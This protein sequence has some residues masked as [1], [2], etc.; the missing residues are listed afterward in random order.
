[1]AHSGVREKMTFLF[2]DLI[3]VYYFVFII[4]ISYYCIYIR[5][6]TCSFSMKIKLFILLILLWNTAHFRAED[7]NEKYVISNITS[8]NGLSNSAVLTIFQDTDGLMWFGTYDGLNCYDSKNMDVFRSN[9][10]HNEEFTFKS[11]IIHKICQAD[12]QCLWVKTFLGVARFSLIKR[13]IEEIYASSENYVIYSNS[14]GDTWVV[15]GDEL[16][17]FNPL[18]KKFVSLGR[19]IP[20]AD[21]CTQALVTDSGELWLL[22]AGSADVVCFKLSAFSASA[23]T[24]VKLGKNVMKLHNVPIGKYHV[25]YNTFSFI[26]A[27]SN[28]YLYDVSAKTKVYIRNISDLMDKY[29]KIENVVSFQGDVI[30]AFHLNGLIRLNASEEYKEEV[31]DRSVRIF[32]M[33]KDR[34]NDIVWVGTD[35]QGVLMLTKNTSIAKTLELTQLSPLLKRQ[36]RS[37]STDRHGGLWIGTKGDGLIH[38]PDYD[39]NW[40]RKE[41]VELY[42]TTSRQSL[43]D[44]IP[45][46][47]DNRVFSI[48]ES[49]FHDG[50]WIGGTNANVLF[51]YSFPKARMIEVEG[52]DTKQNTVEVK[53]VYEEDPST[54]W[55][56]VNMLGLVRLKIDFEGDRIRIVKQSEQGISSKNGDSFLSFFSMM[57]Q[58]DSVLWLGDRGK[59]L[60]RY[61]IRTGKYRIISFQKLLNRPADDILSF[62]QYDDNKFYVG[63]STGVVSMKYENGA[64]RNVSYIGQEHG[65]SNDMIHGILSD[66]NGFLWMSSNKGLNKYNPMNGRIHAFYGNS[67]RVSEFSDGAYYKCPYTGRLFFGGVNGLLYLSDNTVIS[68]RPFQNVI[69]RDFWI[70]NNRVLLPDYEKNGL[71]GYKIN[72]EKG[73]FRFKFIVPD[74][75]GGENIEYSYILEGYDADWSAFS[76]TNDVT[77]S[78]VPPGKYVFKV[79]YKRDINE[80][81][82][83]ILAVPVYITT[84]WYK[85]PFLYILLIVLLLSAAGW[86]LRFCVSNLEWPVLRRKR[87]EEKSSPEVAEETSEELVYYGIRFVIH[88]ADQARLVEKFV[89]IVEANLDN[90]GLGIPFVAAELN[91]STRQFYRKFNEMSVD[92]SPNEFIKLCRLEKAAQLLKGT[93]LSIQEI[94]SAIGIN[95]RSYFYKEFIKKFGCTP[96]DFRN[97]MS[98]SREKE[99]GE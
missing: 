4:Q 32:S 89:S 35:G 15:N 86:G 25:Q 26:D 53:G 45:W 87:N 79:R 96:R 52:F 75:I 55:L 73:Y 68:D 42:S 13:K 93:N 92:I 50:M 64:V 91:L 29:G 84:P 54:L 76:P 78:S 11:N 60:V 27:D 5:T 67:I 99:D 21:K 74:F 40:N 10:P 30:I 63:T 49:R 8:V 62:C 90:E 85:S 43:S 83:K 57:N 37:I 20:E 31:I 69:L 59:G 97:S 72:G 9:S 1:M 14:K 81:N 65:L 71:K 16:L 80:N 70:E 94:I 88:H 56:S 46:N 98:S 12:N 66:K 82:E 17:Y 95:S 48:N 38:I 44:Y 34:Y 61:N 24:K 41:A 6:N 19:V 77:Y 39:V 58:G 36:V 28:L 33:V 2:L 47:H 3:F 18:L 22:Y 51:F 23:A 7:A